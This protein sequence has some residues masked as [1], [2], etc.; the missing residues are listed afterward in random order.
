MN[1]VLLQ[2]NLKILKFYGYDEELLK[3][4]VLDIEKSK[5]GY[6]NIHYQIGDEGKVYIHSQY[7]MERELE[8]LEKPLDIELRDAVYIVYG[9]GLGYHIKVLEKRSFKKLDICNRK[10]CGHYFYV[11][12]NTGLFTNRRKEYNVFIW[13]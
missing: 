3:V 7:N 1:S 5:Q 10:K 9:L 13:D 12:A 6:N 8:M 2:N 4:P 11:Y